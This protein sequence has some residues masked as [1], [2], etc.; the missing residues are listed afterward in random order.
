MERRKRR[1]DRSGRAPLLSPGRPVVAGRDERQRFWASIA[2][3]MASEDAAV[4]AG[5]SQAVGTRLFR[6][7]GDATSNIEAIG[8]AVVRP[9]SLICG[10]GGDRSP[11]RAGLL[12]ARGCAPAWANCFND[13]A[14]VAAQRCH[15]KRR[16]GVSGDDSAMACRAISSPPKAGEACAQRGTASLRGGTTS[17]RRGGSERGSCSR[18]HGVL[19]RSSAWTSEGSAVG[20]RVEPG[21]DRLPPAG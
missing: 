17:W 20:K 21:A 1:S 16:P 15:P 3:G 14:G 9:V 6:K 19:E 8:E 18:P 11:S 12:H 10:A 5:M 2:A 13:L 7:A 4:E